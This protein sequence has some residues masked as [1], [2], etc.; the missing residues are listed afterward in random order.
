MRTAPD[1]Y[2]YF[3]PGFYEMAVCESCQQEVP[4]RDIQE[5]GINYYCPACAELIKE[6]EAYA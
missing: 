3:D 4:D 2:Y 6:T 5:V 1:S